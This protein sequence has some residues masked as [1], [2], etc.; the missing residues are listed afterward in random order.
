VGDGPALLPSTGCHDAG[1]ADPVELLRRE[2]IALVSRLRLWTPARWRAAAPVL[3]SRADV[4]HHLAQRIADVAAELEGQP[5]RPLPRP[6]VDLVLPDQLAVTADDLLRNQPPVA[7]A[8]SVAAHLLLHRGHLLQERV[9]PT[10]AAALGLADVEA[11]GSAVC[12]RV[13]RKRRRSDLAEPD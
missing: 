13:D 5:Q 7:L 8:R 3:G 1:V 4:A 12:A 9:P 2:S 11:I 10:L 6:G